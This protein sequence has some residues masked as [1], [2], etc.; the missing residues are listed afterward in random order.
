M[1]LQILNKQM[2][3][4][5]ALGDFSRSIRRQQKELSRLTPLR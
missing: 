2:H 1:Q 5:A 3:S 4:G